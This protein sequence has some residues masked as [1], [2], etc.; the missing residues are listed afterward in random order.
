MTYFTPLASFL[1]V[2][3]SDAA[4]ASNVTRVAT[5]LFLLVA[6][7]AFG[8]A[9]FAG[10]PSVDSDLDRDYDPLAQMK[11]ALVD[12]L[13]AVFLCLGLASLFLFQHF[14]PLRDD[15]QAG[16]R[17]TGTLE[18]IADASGRYRADNDGRYPR[19]LTQ[20]RLIDPQINKEIIDD[21]FQEVEFDATPDGTGLYVELQSGEDQAYS[22]TLRQGKIVDRS[23]RANAEF[24]VDGSWEPGLGIE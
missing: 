14:K 15:L 4:L 10:V 3:A 19:E 16:Q 8:V 6:S 2:P 7:V 1:G 11:R 20:L 21:R 24:C 23:C 13:G 17:I 18:Q 9:L 5:I 12:L 22:M